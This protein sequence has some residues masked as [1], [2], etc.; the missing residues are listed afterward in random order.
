MKNL[1]LTLTAFVLSLT[2]LISCKKYENI[3][4]VDKSCEQY[5]NCGEVILMVAWQHNS[6]WLM[7]VEIEEYCT[8]DTIHLYSIE[9]DFDTYQIDALLCGLD[10]LN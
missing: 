5:E 4:P 7:D 10:T 6:K 1:T 8:M 9:A 3:E 2:L